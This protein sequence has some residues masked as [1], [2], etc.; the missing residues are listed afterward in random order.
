MALLQARIKL[1]EKVLWLHS[2][3]V[4]ASIAQLDAQRTEGTTEPSTAAFND[5]C[6]DHEGALCLDE[7]LCELEQPTSEA[8]FFGPTSG[9]LELQMS[10]GVA[11]TAESPGFESSPGTEHQGP[12]VASHH[13]APSE[14]G[15]S[16]EPSSVDD[17]VTPGLKGRLIDLYFEWEQ[18]WYQMVDEKL[19]R[20]SM[21]C[22][23]RYSTPLLLCSILAV[24]SRYS[25]ETQVRSDPDDPNTAGRIFFERAEIL[26]R[27]DLRSPSITTIQSLGIMGTYYVVSSGIPPP[28]RGLSPR[29]QLIRHLR[30]GYRL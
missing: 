14:R 19:F 5:M 22:N 7:P 13:V 6:A 17:L 29:T 25:D 27:S 16:I 23:G 9:R 4:D 20:Q 24:G 15:S 26:L 10:H 1:L 2:I 18:P 30:Q 3:D 11:V 28:F 8:R 21:Q 12:V